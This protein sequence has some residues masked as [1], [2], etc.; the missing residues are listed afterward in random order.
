M[1][2][3]IHGRRLMII[4]IC[5]AS[6]AIPFTIAQSIQPLF[7]P[8]VVKTFDFSLASYSLIFTF[9]AVSSAIISPMV[10][11]ILPKINFRVIYL[12]GI[13]LSAIA[14]AGFGLAR[15]L[16]Q[17]YAVAIFCMIGSVFFSGQGI[18]WIINH[19][20]PGKGR[21]TAL[22]LAFAGGSIGN[23][24][25]QPVAA[26]LLK[27]FGSPHLPYIILSVAILAS[28]LII[29][30][31][32]RLPGPDDIP[33]ETTDKNAPTIPVDASKRE[34]REIKDIMADKWFWIFSIGYVLIGMGIAPM[35]NDYAVYLKAHMSISVVGLIGS[36][37]AIGC[38]IGNIG[39]GMLF[40]K[41]GSAKVMAAAGILDIAAVLAM[42]AVG[43]SPVPA[44]AGFIFAICF[45]LAVLSYMSAPAFMAGDL[46]GMKNQGVMLGF[47]GLSYAIGFAVGTPLFGLISEKSGFAGA[48]IIVLAMITI[49]YVLLVA[50]AVKLK[51]KVN[52]K[53]LNNERK[54]TMK[55]TTEK[56]NTAFDAKKFDAK[57]LDA[58]CSSVAWTTEDGKHIWARNFDFNR[59]AEGS[60]V[61][62]IPREKDYYICGTTTEGTAK[63]KNL[64]K[65]KYASIGIGS[66]ALGSTPVLYDGMNEMG[67]MGGQQNY[68]EFAFFPEKEKRG[69]KRLQPPFVV[70]HVLSQCATVEEATALLENEVTIVAEPML[71]TVPTLHWV[72][73]DRSGETIVVESDIDGLHIYRNT[74]GVMTNSPGYSWHKLNL[75][76]YAGIRDL[77]HDTYTIDGN[78]INQAFSGSGAF[79]MP[80]DWTSPS[81]FVRLAFLKEYCTKGKTEEEGITYLMRIMTNAAFPL[82]MVRVSDPGHITE[83]EKDIVP[84]DYTIYTSAMCAESLKFYWISY[85]NQRIQCVDMNMLL[86]AKDYMQFPLKREIDFAYLTEKDSI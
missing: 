35:A 82:G 34:G 42:L 19:W 71:G 29:S 3:K 65:T 5:M 56:Y 32:I 37:F 12:T 21:G 43:T 75:L 73:S 53:H 38:L 58:G 68:R 27:Y 50:A 67:L 44:T 36:V 25:M 60:L 47:V 18:P 9:G 16:P 57:E 8:Y 22:G 10:G 51:R 45:G 20:F 70:T 6:Q 41:F 62:F 66:I 46:F 63:P 69:T 23:F 77:D 15:N 72:F 28:G 81:R 52:P 4:L 54:A 85:E 64:T 13:I 7:V 24:F 86:D 83:K 2:E 33:Q 59:I 17:F 74:V 1:N 48:W 40:D 79:G 11:K 61:T 78:T 84:F 26:D 30:F 14:F 55:N 31:F 39:G 49:G 80:G 76:N